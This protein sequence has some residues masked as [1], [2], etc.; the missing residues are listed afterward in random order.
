MIDIVQHSETT[1]GTV[2]LIQAGR[3]YWVVASTPL[4]D[5]SVAN[6]Y[7]G[8]DPSARVNAHAGWRRAVKNGKTA[9][10]DEEGYVAWQYGSY[11]SAKVVDA[12]CEHL[13]EDVNYDDFDDC[14]TEV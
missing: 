5:G 1:K 3:D 8:Y 11:F 7:T 10:V 6:V 2:V 14:D 9:T 13:R 12:I 4:V